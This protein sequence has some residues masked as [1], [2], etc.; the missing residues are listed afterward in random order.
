MKNV[1]F[2]FVFLQVKKN[3]MPEL[4]EC[5]YPNFHLNESHYDTNL[6]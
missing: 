6:V 4:L 1:Y 3:T 5:K 2:L